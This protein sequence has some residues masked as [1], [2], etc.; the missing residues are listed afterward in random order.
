MVSGEHPEA[1]WLAFFQSIE[2]QGR[3]FWREAVQQTAAAPGI[4]GGNPGDAF[5]ELWRVLKNRDRFDEEMDAA[6]EKMRGQVDAA[7]SAAEPT[8]LTDA[9]AVA[10][11]KAAETGIGDEAQ[12]DPPLWLAPWV[13]SIS[14][15]IGPFHE[16]QQTLNELL[17]ALDHHQEA[18]QRCAALLHGAAREGLSRFQ[19]R[20]L[21]AL[22]GNG[23]APD[24]LRGLY[25]MWLTESE[26]VYDELL[27]GDA[28]A[29]AFADLSNAS[30][31]LLS[32]CREHV[33]SFLV[34]LGF[35]NRR[36]LVDTQRRLLTVERQQRRQAE[37]SNTA[38][39]LDEVEKLRREVA[40]LQ[41]RS[42]SK[43]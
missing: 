36:D 21:A 26:A 3:A 22:G 12:L 19:T 42:G 32:H 18:H 1:E 30:A 14:H 29:A 13:Y 40:A 34:M 10:L 23:E 31:Q 11:R 37:E 27:A 5:S 4:P 7:F 15:R 28:W 43:R 6:F 24:T 16:E 25:E 41:R 17:L 35:P 33:D 8:T 39:L 2:R 38:K 20:V 9:L